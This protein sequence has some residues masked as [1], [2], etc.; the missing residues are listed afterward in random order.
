M[1]VGFIGNYSYA[2]RLAQTL[3]GTAVL[4][5]HRAYR[6]SFGEAA[7]RQFVA[8]REI[9]ILVVPQGEFSLN[10]LMALLRPRIG[11]QIPVL[12]LVSD[13]PIVWEMVTAVTVQTK[14]FTVEG[15][16]AH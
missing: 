9:D 8:D 16:E 12:R 6:D 13:S 14:P 3:K 4:Y 5:D 15:A 7:I 1:N 10:T 2:Q 11:L